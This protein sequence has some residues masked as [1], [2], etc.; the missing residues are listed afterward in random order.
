MAYIAM[1][2]A[3]S[4]YSTRCFPFFPFTALSFSRNWGHED[5]RKRYK[6]YLEYLSIR[7]I[8]VG[9]EMDVHCFSPTV[10]GSKCAYNKLSDTN[11]DEDLYYEW[12][13][14]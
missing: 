13:A 4:K 2:S 1:L 10:E 5:F 8:N 14:S 12:E 9:Y 3:C 11:G 7:D 6:L